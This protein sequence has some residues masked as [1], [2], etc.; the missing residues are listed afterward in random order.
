MDRTLRVVDEHGDERPI[1]GVDR[2]DWCGL[3]DTCPDCGSRRFRHFEARGSRMEAGREGTLVRRSD[4]WDAVR[5]LFVQ[6]LGCRSVLSKHPA[7]D[8]LFAVE[9]ADTL[10]IDD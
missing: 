3:P 1:S 8:L 7:M 4:Y 6:C 10:V 5:T 9:G 2:S